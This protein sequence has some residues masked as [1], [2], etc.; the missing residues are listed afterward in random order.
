MDNRVAGCQLPAGVT[1]LLRFG[2]P[3]PPGVVGMV[4]APGSASGKHPFYVVCRCGLGCCVSGGRCVGVG[5]WGRGPLVMLHVCAL[6]VGGGGCVWVKFPCRRCGPTLGVGC[7]AGG[8]ARGGWCGCPPLL[9]R[10]TISL[11]SAVL[12]A[13]CCHVL[14][15]FIM[16]VCR[17]WFA[18]LRC[19]LHVSALFATL[20]AILCAMCFCV[21]ASFAVC[22][23]Q[24]WRAALRSVRHL[25]KGSAVRPQGL[26]QVEFN[27]C[28][29][30]VVG[31]DGF[32]VQ[33]RATKGPHH[34]QGQEIRVKRANVVRVERPTTNMSP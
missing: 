3:S 1:P 22:L 23:S 5:A 15:R 17:L 24:F 20:P 8:G 18:A 26:W 28:E 27:A 16:C 4:M 31:H 34:T 33:V 2:L 21:L 14:A 29:A 32:R 11:C 13:A 6:F 25:A 9:L 12:C 7:W 30:M 19:V 10:S